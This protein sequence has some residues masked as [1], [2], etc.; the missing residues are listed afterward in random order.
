MLYSKNGSI[1]KP[2]T[3]GTEGWIQVEEAP[4]PG[5]GQEVVWWFPPG[6]VVRPLKPAE[7]ESFVWDWSQSQ[8]KWVKS[9][10]NVIVITPDIGVDTMPSASANDTIT[11]GSAAETIS[12]A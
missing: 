10:I 8:E 11:L 7:E 4:T 3:D 12:G 2:Q 5:E 9:E 1:P 6:W